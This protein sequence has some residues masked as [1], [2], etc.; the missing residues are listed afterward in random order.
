MKAYCNLTIRRLQMEALIALAAA[1]A[2]E[3][4]GQGTVSFSNAGLNANVIMGIPFTV[5]A[6]TYNVGD[7]APA[8]TTFSVAL[9][10]APYD[11]AS[12][13]PPSQSSFM[14]LG[15]SANLL[16]PGIYFAGVR[17]AP[18]SPP[19]SPAWFEVKAWETA[20][21]SSYEQVGAGLLAG[22][23]IIR[24]QTED[25]TTGGSPATLTG[26]GTIVLNGDPTPCVPEPSTVLLA[27]L[28]ALVL[29]CLSR[30]KRTW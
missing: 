14:Q 30:G 13:T 27:F 2:L 25:P 4:Y 5:G 17:T 19:G 20:C 28:G 6:N 18:V 21:G 7:K 12:P 3:L 16:L 1:A 8:G 29:V 10:F 24:V 15:A 22:S 11:P 9:Y 26:I 23:D